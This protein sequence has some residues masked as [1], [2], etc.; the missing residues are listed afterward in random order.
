LLK[1][2]EDTA[3]NAHWRFGAKRFFPGKIQKFAVNPQ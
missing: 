2:H 1:W 3:L